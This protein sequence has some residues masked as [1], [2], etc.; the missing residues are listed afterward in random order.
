MRLFRRSLL[1]VIGAI[2]LSISVRAQD[3]AVVAEDAAPPLVTKF[4]DITLLTTVRQQF[5]FADGSDNRPGAMHQVTGG[6][7]G[8]QAGGKGGGGLGGG[9]GAFSLPIEPAQFGGGSGAGGL[10]G[11]GFGSGA[12][13]IQSVEPA[14][15]QQLEE[16]GESISTLIVN[17]IDP[18]SWTNS[19]VGTGEITELGN[20]L[21]IRQTESVHRQ[22]AEF[23]KSLTMAAIGTGTYQVEVW[24]LPTTEP[25]TMQLKNLL[26]GN[27]EE[28]VVA[29]QLATLCQDEGGYHGILL[30]PDR[31]TTHMASGKKVPVIIGSTP[32]VG[33]GSAGHSP[34]VQILHLGL[35]LEARVTSV[36]DY[37]IPE[38]D[39]K[40]SDQIDLNFRSQVTSP[41]AHVQDR[42]TIEK[43]DRYELGEHTAAGSCR[44]RIGTPT[45][46][47][48]L[49]QLS[50][51]E[52]DATE[53]PPELQL[54]VWVTRI[55]D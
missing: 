47:T 23:L 48:S 27:L 26:H 21:L 33:T 20:T 30:C 3:D 44:I 8:G 29:E 24:W 7:G 52:P 5:P 18:Q 55:A 4:Y 2:T 39:G 53:I 46:I 11:G 28:A 37:L 16:R 32:V 6:F 1:I 31:V 42:A 13:Q 45:L 9:G 50:D 34:T 12:A 19:G 43:I 54:V 22:V 35:M 25:S 36:P 41:D 17:H 10:G 14:L 40:K 15:T 38:V 49:T 51:Q